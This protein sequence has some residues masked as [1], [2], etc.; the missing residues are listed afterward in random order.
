ML[1]LA[2]N[3]NFPKSAWIHPI[4]PQHATA[5]YTTPSWSS[6]GC[7]I[8]VLPVIGSMRSKRRSKTVPSV[9]HSTWV[10]I[11]VATLYSFI[12]EPMTISQWLIISTS[13]LFLHLAHVNA[14]S[15]ALWTPL[16]CYGAG[17]SW[18]IAKTWLMTWHH[19]L[20]SKMVGCLRVLDLLTLYLSRRSRSCLKNPWFS[21][22]FG[23]GMPW[24]KRGMLEHIDWR[25]Q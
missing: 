2:S 18:L 1:Q 11:M 9:H 25:Q 19:P 15:S 17:I 7:V 6:C 23:H 21:N 16:R 20:R 5:T 10:G 22:R 3:L 24:S 14:S 12:F 13:P 8:P 4:W